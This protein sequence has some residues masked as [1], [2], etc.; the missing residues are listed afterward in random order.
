MKRYMVFTY[1]DYYPRG[2]ANDLL[3]VFDILE[4]SLPKLLEEF[5]FN[6]FENIQFYDLIKDK[7]VNFN[8]ETSSYYDDN[9]QFLYD[10]KYD[11]LIDFKLVF[12]EAIQKA[13]IELSK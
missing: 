7:K 4:E 8:L 6:K 10:W 5:K 13:S 2:G 12:E 11:D 1:K 3:E 9:R